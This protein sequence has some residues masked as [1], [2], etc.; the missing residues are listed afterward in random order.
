[1]RRIAGILFFAGMAATALGLVL[2]IAAAVITRAAPLQFPL[3]IAFFRYGIFAFA[4]A[5]VVAFPGTLF[6]TFV[7]KHRRAGIAMATLLVSVFVV[8]QAQSLMNKAKSLPRIHDISTDTEDPPRFQAVVAL[9]QGVA[10]NDLAFDPR[11]IP[12]Q[13]TA[14]PD[15]QPVFLTQPISQAFELALKAARAMG[16]KIIHHSEA[17]G[18]IEATDTTLFFGFKDDVAIRLRRLDEQTRIDVRSVSRVGLS[19]IGANADRILTYLE[20]VKAASRG[21]QD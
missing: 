10:A 17:E 8:Y 4:A 16:W 20:K 9:R 19:D 6:N 15:V 21:P 3:G 2:T 5:G 14:Y 18:L 11:N 12:L 1:M 13:K 7:Q